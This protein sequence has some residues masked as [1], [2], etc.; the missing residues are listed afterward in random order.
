MLF[1]AVIRSK[2]V[3][4][5]LFMKLGLVDQAFSLEAQTCIRCY[6]QKSKYQH[7]S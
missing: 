6:K 5:V 4:R 1:K 3:I 7:T 2:S